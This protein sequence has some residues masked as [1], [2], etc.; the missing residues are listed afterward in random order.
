M[1]P[2]AWRTSRTEVMASAVARER[3]CTR[4]RAMSPAQNGRRRSAASQKRHCITCARLTGALGPRPEPRRRRRR[5]GP[6]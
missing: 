4:A 5:W 2:R 1:A 3:R 6:K